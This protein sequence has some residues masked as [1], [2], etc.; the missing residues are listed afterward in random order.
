MKGLLVVEKAKSGMS[1]RGQYKLTVTCRMKSL[2]SEAVGLFYVTYKLNLIPVCIVLETL[3]EILGL[4]YTMHGR[5][6]VCGG[7]GPIG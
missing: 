5:R 4:T 1:S 3:Q 2:T 7:R 6:F